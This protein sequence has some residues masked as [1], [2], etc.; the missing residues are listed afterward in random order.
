MNRSHPTRGAWIEIYRKASRRCFTPRRTPRGV[1]GL[2]SQH[3][4]E[5][6]HTCSSHPTRGAWIEI[7]SPEQRAALLTRRTPRGVRGLKSPC[8]SP[9]TR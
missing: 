4:R 3:L 5:K 2:K 1:R 7:V 6:N 9:M 8:P